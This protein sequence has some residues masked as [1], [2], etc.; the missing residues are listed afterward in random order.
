MGDFL[1][2]LVVR[3]DLSGNPSFPELLKRV[4]NVILSAYANQDVPFEQV[5][6]ALHPDRHV[7][8]NPLFQV[9]FV[10]Q[11]P[12]T[13]DKLGWR[14]SQLEVDSGCSK[15]NLTFN[16]EERPEGMIGAI[17]YNTDLFDATTIDRA[18]GH[19]MT[20][21]EGIVA[22]P[23]TSIAQLPLL[24]ESECHQLL[25]EWNNTQLDYPRDKCIHQ[26]FEEQVE[27][28]PDAV[29]VVCEEQKLTYHQLNCQAN[30]LAHY[31]QTLG[32]RPEVLVGICVER[33]L[34]MVVGLL[35][36]M[37]AGGAYVPLDP[38]YPQERVD[39]ILSNSETKVLITSS[40]L[41]SSL[42]KNE[43]QAI[44]LD[45]DWEIIYESN[46]TNPESTVKDRKS[47]V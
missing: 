43:T 2:T 47:V 12:L 26:L 25:V 46:K 5:V 27:K 17:E 29:A 44:C 31:L 28:T 8:Q 37:K 22:N 41:L 23:E 6:N 30:Q 33:S 10:L 19:L 35:G 39:Y 32:V 13:D 34:E 38:N 15:F 21:L 18:I 40:Q 24:T 9:M 20:L 42:A 7:S 36:I 14:V 3:S 11:P 16:L 4:R 45:T 1:N